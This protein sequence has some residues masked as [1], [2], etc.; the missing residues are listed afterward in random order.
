MLLEMFRETTFI[1]EG[2]DFIRLGQVR[3]V[4]WRQL[5]VAAAAITSLTCPTVRRSGEQLPLLSAFRTGSQQQTSGL[6]PLTS[7]PV[8]EILPVPDCTI[9]I[10]PDREARR[11]WEA[12]VPGVLSGDF[13]CTWVAHA[14]QIFSCAWNPKQIRKLKPGHL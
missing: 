12:H 5:H 3:V 13:L 7:M 14:H 1:L 2:K 8:L 4:S 11:S 10:Q 6:L 9:M